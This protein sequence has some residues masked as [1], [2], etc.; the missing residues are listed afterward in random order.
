MPPKNHALLGASNAGRWL[1]CPGSARLTEYMPDKPTK[2][3]QAGTLAHA[4]AELKARK[5]FVEP[6]STRTYNSRLKKLRSDPSYDSG[7][8]EATDAYLDHLKERAMSYPAAPCVALE[9]KV[10][11]SDIV[12]EGFGTADCV[13][14]GSGCLDVVDY[15]NGTGVVVSAERNPQ[16]MLYAW[17]ALNYFSPIFGDSIHV[18]HLS[19]VQ[20]NAGGVRE[21]SLTVGELRDWMENTVRPAAKKAYD[22]VPEFHSGDWCQFCKARDTC[23]Q[24]ANEMFEVEPLMGTEPTLLTDAE[25]GDVLTRAKSLAAWAKSL[26]DYVLRSTL[27]GHPIPGWKAVAGRKSR[28][29]IGGEDAAFPELQNRGVAEALLYERN[30]V[31]VAKLEKALGKKLFEETAAGLW[32]DKP[33]APALKPES[34]PRPPYNLAQAAFGVLDNG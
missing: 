8:E 29:W 33:G 6:M 25:I 7:M 2:S 10:N 21:W 4:I 34:D 11:Y 18:I 15:K 14:I 19:I 3:T 28:V 1:N 27:S 16:M 22:G 9:L 31:S 12:P 20:P 24:R 17:G 30:P 5:Y 23:R 13:M 32:E 26:E